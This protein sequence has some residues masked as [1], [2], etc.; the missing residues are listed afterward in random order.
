M[1]KGAW[2]EL[3]IELSNKLVTVETSIHPEWAKLVLS[4]A[5]SSFIT[6]RYYNSLKEGEG[7]DIEP[8]LLYRCIGT[9][10]YDTVTKRYY[11]ELEVGFLKMVKDR[12]IQYC[13]PKVGQE[14]NYVQMKGM[15]D[16][17]ALSP[18]VMQMTNKVFYRAEGSRKIV[19]KNLEGGVCELLLLYVPNIDDLSD[20]DEVPVPSEFESEVIKICREFITGKKQLPDDKLADDNEED[21]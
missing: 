6:A 19:F 1:T 21:K 10:Q 8:S 9:P 15:S 18:N 4:A 17:S 5:V 14:N 13:G 2:T 3:I 12:A 11:I 20:D 16:E 7:K